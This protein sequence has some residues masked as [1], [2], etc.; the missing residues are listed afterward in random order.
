MT[1]SPTLNLL[2]DIYAVE[3]RKQ[4]DGIEFVP[5]EDVSETDIKEANH[6]VQEA[7]LPSN[8]E[9]DRTRKGFLAKKALLDGDKETFIAW[10]EEEV[11]REE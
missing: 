8:D 11:A 7:T 4:V 3:L 5:P 1:I 6:V 2:L 10:L 9:V